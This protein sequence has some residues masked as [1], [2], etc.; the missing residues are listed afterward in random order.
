MFIIAFCPYIVSLLFRNRD[1]TMGKAGPCLG[2][3]RSGLDLASGSQVNHQLQN[4][5][6]C[7][8]QYLCSGS[9]QLALHDFGPPHH[10][11]I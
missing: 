11:L 7:L 8:C 1:V 2:L 4:V 6:T 9:G 3:F 10:G 5:T